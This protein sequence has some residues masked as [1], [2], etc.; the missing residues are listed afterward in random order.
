MPMVILYP[1]KAHVAKGHG[2][3]TQTVTQQV[4]D[5][6]IQTEKRLSQA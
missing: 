4:F 1:D 2:R 6:G 5:D 3:G